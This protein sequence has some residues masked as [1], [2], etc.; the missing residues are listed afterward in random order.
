V[1]LYDV[2]ARFFCTYICLNEDCVE[3]FKEHTGGTVEDIIKC[4]SLDLI[5][6]V[7]DET[8]Q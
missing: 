7:E 4:V 2:V 8:R 6:A 5:Y 1:P 3:T